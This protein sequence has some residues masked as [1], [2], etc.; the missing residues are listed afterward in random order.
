MAIFDENRRPFSV[1]ICNCEGRGP[2][3]NIFERCKPR[4]TN[5]LNEPYEQSEIFRISLHEIGHGVDDLL[6]LSADPKFIAAHRRDVSNLSV[7]DKERWSYYTTPI[8]A[9]AEIIGGLAGPKEVNP[10][11]ADMI[12]C[13]PQT[14]RWL[15][16]RLRL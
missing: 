15:K 14:T 11:T 12:K 7:E 10:Y 6:Q 5:K 4:G 2:D 8:E 3:I 9:C 13:F 16:E 1:R